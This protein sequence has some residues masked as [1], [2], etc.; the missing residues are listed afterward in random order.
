MSYNDYSSYA[1]SADI[2]EGLIILI[3]LAFYAAVFVISYLITIYPRYYMVKTSG[4]GPVWTAFIP[5]VNDIQL[6]K[7]AGYK[8][9]TYFLYL[10]GIGLSWLPIVGWIASICSIIF[11]CV[12]YWKVSGNFGLG[13]LGKVLTLFLGTW[14]HWYIA[15]ARKPYCVVAQY[16]NYPPQNNNPNW[17][18]Q[19]NPQAPEQNQNWYQNNN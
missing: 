17:Y 12:V 8:W 2:S 11:L 10:A 9:W 15:L 13:T 4:V 16:G 6:F 14:V 3:A 19:P 18:Q 5:V 1:G 7:M